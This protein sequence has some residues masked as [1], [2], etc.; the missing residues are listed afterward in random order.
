MLKEVIVVAAVCFS[1]FALVYTI[2]VDYMSQHY[3]LSFAGISSAFSLQIPIFYYFLKA[4][5]EEGRREYEE[6]K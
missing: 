4:R 2:S 5:K 3:A 1:V 6:R